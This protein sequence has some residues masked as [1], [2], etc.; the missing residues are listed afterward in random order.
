[1]GSSKNPSQEPTNGDPASKAAGVE[2]REG[3]SGGCGRKPGLANIT[4]ISGAD[5]LGDLGS[6]NW[7]GSDL[8]GET[9]AD[10]GSG[11]ITEFWSFG[12]GALRLG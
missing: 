5:R 1:M 11:T 10:F 6:P 12:L 2:D 4:E 3:T 8:M 9:G 7:I